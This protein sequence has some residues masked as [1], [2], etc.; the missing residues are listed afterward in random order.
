[1]LGCV[2]EMR[3]FRLLAGCG[4][5]TSRIT[6]SVLK[7]P[8]INVDRVVRL[9]DWIDQ[10][11]ASEELHPPRWSS[12][13]VLVQRIISMGSVSMPSIVV[14]A[15]IIQDSDGRLLTVRKR[16]AEAFMLPG[17]K[18]EPGEDSRQAVVREVH[19]ELGVALSSDDL[20]RVGVFTT[21]AANEA[22]HQVVATIFT[23]TSVAVSEPAAE[24]EQIR[25]LDWSVDALPDDLAPL[26]VEAVIP[27]LRRRIRS[28]AVF[29]GAK[30]GTDPH[31]R[32]EATALGR[33]LAHAGITLVYGG[34]KVGMMG[35]VAD[36]ALAA[37]GAVIGVMP[38]HLVDGEIA[39]PSLTH[40]EVVRT[41]HERKQRMSDLADAFVALP[42]G[43]GTL[44][45][46]FEA[47]TWQQLGVHSKPVALYDS[48][49][50]APL[51]ALL[52]HM[53]IE[54]FIR[55]EDRASLVIADTIHQ[56]MADL[57]G[58]TP[59]PPKWRS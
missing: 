52:N 54:G 58:W 47:W 29:T 19:E 27:W 50:W 16:G 55:P 49:F 7:V 20:R 24:I 2:G 12:G 51:T 36:A 59:P 45:E 21:R 25:W 34:G 30:D 5:M 11:V 44:D 57:E 4:L 13:R 43:G 9:E 33:G 40:L 17:G 42:G 46:L 41:M 23:H 48:T 14:S 26:L 56:L 3:I 35:A 6:G 1:M 32:V 18:P 38:Q 31:Y 39:H 37:G 15:V 10:P 22:G 8:C 28:V 53:T